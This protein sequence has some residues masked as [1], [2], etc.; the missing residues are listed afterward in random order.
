[1]KSPGKFERMW[2]LLAIVTCVALVTA[3]VI[4]GAS[5]RA[6]GAAAASSNDARYTV[7]ETDGELL[8]VTDNST[9]TLYFYTHDQGAEPGSPVELRGSIDLN[10]VGKSEIPVKVDKQDQ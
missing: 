5:R 9:N 3:F 10:K 2:P 6:D 4:S 1:M 8:I 7:V